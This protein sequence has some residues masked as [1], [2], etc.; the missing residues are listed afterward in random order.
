LDINEGASAF[1]LAVLPLFVEPSF[2]SGDL[3]LGLA[4]AAPVLTTGQIFLEHISNLVVCLISQ[5]GGFM[6]KS[7]FRQRPGFRGQHL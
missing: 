1:Y 2:S 3:V 7:E 4:P 6:M 5:K